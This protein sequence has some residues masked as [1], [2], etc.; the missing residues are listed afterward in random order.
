MARLPDG[1]SKYSE[2]PEFT[3]DTVPEKLTR[4]HDTKDGTWGR[5]VVLEGA[6]TYVVPGPPVAHCEVT[7]DAPVIIVPKLLHYVAIDGPV[8]FKV[9]FWK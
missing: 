2:T 7:P 4:H 8:R 1:V 5:L 9:Q 3:Q 6:L